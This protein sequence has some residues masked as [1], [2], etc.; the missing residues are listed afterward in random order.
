MSA[1]A[2][3]TTLSGGSMRDEWIHG[4][5]PGSE[6]KWK[7]GIRVV[8]NG[9]KDTLESATVP[10]EWRFSEGII[11]E[12]PQYI[13]ICDHEMS[14]AR[15]AKE[16]SHSFGRRHLV[17]VTEFATYLQLFKTGKHH[18]IF[19]VFCGERKDALQ[20]AEKFME[21]AAAGRGYEIS[22][23][24]S[25]V[26]RGWSLHNK[27]TR[28]LFV[29]NIEVELPEGLLA[30]RPKSVFGKFVWNWSN[31]YFKRKPTDE[32]AYRKRKWFALIPTLASFA[33]G[34]TVTGIALS[35]YSIFLWL[36][37]LY[38]GFRPMNLFAN[39]KHAWMNLH[40]FNWK[41][42]ASTNWRC[43]RDARRDA[44]TGEWEEA[45]YLPVWL[46][47]S[48][49]SCMVAAPFLF[50]KLCKRFPTQMISLAAIVIVV[51]FV[52]LVLYIL[53][54]IG[55]SRIAN[56]IAKGSKQFCIDQ[57]EAFKRYRREKAERVPQTEDAK[58][59]ASLQ[60]ISLRVAPA[61]A[62][63]DI[64]AAIKRTSMPIKFKLGFWAAKS[65]VCKPFEQ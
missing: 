15:L 8:V 46:T 57:R 27:Y 17:K 55:N 35:L 33:I 23:N 21:P 48:I 39:I 53:A 13:V 28:S 1:E 4:Q 59:F 43:M 2:H 24:F 38:A 14:H 60:T 54:W 45:K 42:L 50:I 61:P 11:A 29:A 56:A 22:L 44:G 51:G 62:R 18:L 20:R 41:M 37:F 3:K 32:C 31:R 10:I 40:A 34:R 63:V 19:L 7:D 9:G 30:P 65:K 5:K 49:I 25:L 26:E 64:P 12:R 36:L 58:L 47:P 16:E 6:D 52:V